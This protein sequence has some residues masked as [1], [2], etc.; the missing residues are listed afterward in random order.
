MQR[1]LDLCIQIKVKFGR[2]LCLCL[3]LIIFQ[4]WRGSRDS[5]WGIPCGMKHRQRSDFNLNNMVLHETA[6]FPRIKINERAP[7]NACTSILRITPMSDV[8]SS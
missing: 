8:S 2:L 1:E 7:S 5:F 3:L 4:R 6:T